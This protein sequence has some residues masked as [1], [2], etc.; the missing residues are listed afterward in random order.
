MNSALNRKNTTPDQPYSNF[1]MIQCVLNL[2]NERKA[3]SLR[4]KVIKI[5]ALLEDSNSLP[6]ETTPKVDI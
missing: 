1:I 5:Y 2:G 6:R 3:Q 4:I